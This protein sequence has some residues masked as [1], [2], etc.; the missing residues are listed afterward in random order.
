MRD[1]KEDIK[2]DKNNLADE[3]IEHP[4][5]YL[6]YSE[7]WAEAI[8]IRDQL[9]SKLEYVYAKS[10]SYIRKNW[11]KY[12]EKHPTE[13]AIKNW[14]IQSEKYRKVESELL[15]AQKNVN[16]LASIKSAFEHRKAALQN[17]VSLQ[18]SGFHS[19]PSSVKRNMNEKLSASAQRT[20]RKKRIKKSKNQG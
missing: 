1:F 15:E 10:D 18:I 5:L 2:I 11:K 14:I 6:Y 20:L 12:Y 4:S 7:L 19:D 9:K 8:Y 16:L 3:W 17:Y 13:G